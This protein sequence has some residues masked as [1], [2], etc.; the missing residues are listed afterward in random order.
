MEA[1]QRSIVD[2]PF[3]VLDNIL[4]NQ[5]GGLYENIITIRGKNEVE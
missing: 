3:S 4:V 2:G 5:K 1:I